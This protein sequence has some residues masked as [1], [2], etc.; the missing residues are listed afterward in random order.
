MAG[1][2]GDGS[3]IGADKA[4]GGG[5]G[6]GALEQAVAEALRRLRQD[7]EFPWNGGCNQ[8]SVRGPLHLLDGIDGGQADDGGSVLNDGV[9]GALDGGG[10]DQGPDR[11]V[12]EDDVVRLGG[13][14]GERMGHRL[15]PV[16]AAF[17]DLDAVGEPVVGHLGLHAFHL[18]LPNCHVDCADPPDLGKGA[19]GVNQD[20][21]PIEGKELFGLRAGHPCSQTRRG[22][23]RKDLHNWWSIQHGEGGLWRYRTERYDPLV[24][25]SLPTLSIDTTLLKPGLRVGVGLSG[26]ADSVALLRI[27]AER[28]REL[29][30]VL[31]V[32]HLHHGLR[33]AEADGDLDFCRELAG[34]LGLTFHEAQVDTGAAALAD[35]GAGKAAETIEEAARRLRYGWFRELMASGVVDAVAT[36][37][38]LDD[39]AETVLARF[40]RGAWTEGLSGIY[41]VVQFSEGRILRPLLATTRARSKPTWAGLARVGGKTLPIV[42]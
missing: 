9:D 32:A 24:P 35:A 14:R 13:E 6:E 4:I 33:G 36:A 27:L 16:V 40:L 1:A 31:H 23:N 17:H 19:Q 8:R 39:Q 22:E 7:D 5:L 25:A 18:R 20:R 11:V 10:V 12:D 29:G 34:R 37:H 2:L 26:G 28:S 21:N 38:T 3:L 15:L 30:L 41:P 42:I